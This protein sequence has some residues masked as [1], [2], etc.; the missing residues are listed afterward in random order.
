MN[1]KYLWLLRILT[2]AQF[3]SETSPTQSPWFWPLLSICLVLIIGIPCIFFIVFIICRVK[4]KINYDSDESSMG[5]NLSSTAPLPT[6]PVQL[7]RQRR[8]IRHQR[9]HYVDG[10][11]TP[12]PPYTTTEQPRTLFVTT[13]PPPLYESHINE[14]VPTTNPSTA[15]NIQ[16]T[17]S[18]EN[19]TTTDIF[20]VSSSTITSP[21]M[22]TFQV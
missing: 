17:E 15:I 20:D 18:I 9:S 3:D 16:S 10:F 7:E 6:V 4:Y 11:R 12:P 8:H 14:N 19:P 1:C 21:S 13:S 5:S 22:Q 2:N